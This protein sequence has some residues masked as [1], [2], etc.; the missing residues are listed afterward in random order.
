MEQSGLLVVDDDPLILKLMYRG[1]SDLCPV[2]L[3]RSGEE[4]LRIARTQKPM[5]IIT[6]LVMPGM[7]GGTLVA[8]LKEDKQ[9]SDIPFIIMTGENDRSAEARELE[10]GAADFIRKPIEIDV[11]RQRVI[12]VL[13]TEN[14]RKTL[15]NLA[16]T[17][18]L[19]GAYNRAYLEK[20]IQESGECPGIFFLVDLDHFKSVNDKL[21]HEEGDT[22]ICKFYG[23]LDRLV[24]KE[25]VIA[26]IGGDEFAVWCE[27]YT[28]RRLIARR[29]RKIVE[30]T[31]GELA[32]YGV[33]VSIG[34]AMKPSDG[35]DFSSLY[36]KADEAM[37]FVKNAGKSAYLFYGD[38]LSD[39]F[40]RNNNNDMGA[41]AV[42]RDDFTSILKFLA[43]CA[44]R[45]NV[46]M[47][48][49]V[50]SFES[51][52]Y[53]EHHDEEIA[54]I[55]DALR[56]SDVITQCGDS[57]YAVILSGTDDDG[58]VV[59]ASRIVEAWERKEQTKKMKF[60]ICDADEMIERDMFVKN[61]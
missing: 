14:E 57:E 5:L 31:R 27:N 39:D 9:T 55:K 28:D 23:I 49:L 60:R 1:L 18:T 41:M 34:A 13:K 35:E 11:L 36:E 26:R 50:F 33:T 59:A 46:P 44:G 54:F 19:T 43:R 12:N 45:S 24:R 8:S 51:E 47:S 53:D 2:T 42:G 61:S 32:Y 20:T 16:E 25:D 17:D 52:A 48:V 21:G 10:F 38:T 4:A 58:S 30:M 40:E 37:Y 29:L 56:I 22:V 7:D 15:R 3:S 6:D